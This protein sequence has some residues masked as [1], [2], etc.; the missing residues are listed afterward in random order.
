MLVPVLAA[1]HFKP[2]LLVRD[3]GR[4]RRLFRGLDCEF[5]QADLL[6]SSFDDLV[7]ACRGCCAVVH[8]AGSADYSLSERDLV[9][10]NYGGTER[11]VV[12]AKRA[13]VKRFVFL[14]STSVYG[15]RPRELPVTEKTRFSPSNAYGRSKLLAEY[16]VKRARIPFV[17]LRPTVIYGPGFAAG[18]RE[19]ARALV[20][21][22]MFLVGDGSN[23]VPLV[24][25][26][27]VVQAIVLALKSGKLNE[28]YLIAGCEVLTQE[29]VLRMLARALKVLP[30]QKKI[31]KWLALLLAGSAEKRE[32]VRVLAEDRVFSLDKAQKLLGF[33][34]KRRLG[35]EL[36]KLVPFLLGGWR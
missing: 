19:V 1:K 6:R 24:H 23:R 33:R 22:K 12:A 9:A 17:I 16:A 11:I 5:V 31:P 21:G 28:D 13:G 36:V 3:E 7:H 4:A 26:D 34:P 15:A 20:K 30:P 27:D 14:S 2:R 29:Q 18:F 35:V 10:L 25:V 32:Y 8:L